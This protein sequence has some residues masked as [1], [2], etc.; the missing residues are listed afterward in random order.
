MAEEPKSGGWW[1]TVPGVLTAVAGF[2]SA[3]AAL[4]IALHQVGI[5]GGEEPAST[6]ESKPSPN[7]ARES[8]KLVVPATTSQGSI[9]DEIINARQPAK[10]TKPLTKEEI[11]SV[12]AEQFHKTS[13]DHGEVQQAWLTTVFAGDRPFQQRLWGFLKQNYGVG[14]PMT[15]GGEVGEGEQTGYA[16]DVLQTIST[17]TCILSQPNND[18]ACSK[19]DLEYQLSMLKFNARDDYP[20]VKAF[21]DECATFAQ[22]LPMRKRA[23]IQDDSN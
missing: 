1:Q 3:M 13:N 17:T 9:L 16:Y 22:G 19:K 18:K 20:K 5:V 15:M 7:P 6:L 12:L 21:L 11:F 23:Y 14:N 10:A 4:I 8:E 2:I